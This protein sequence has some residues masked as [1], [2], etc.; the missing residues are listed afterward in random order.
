MRAAL[1]GL[2]D[3]LL[4][5]DL[6]TELIKA[7]FDQGFSSLPDIHIQQRAQGVLEA[8]VS[9]LQC[10]KE[11]SS[12]CCDNPCS[13]SVLQLDKGLHHTSAALVS[14]S[15]ACPH[16]NEADVRVHLKQCG[17]VSITQEHRTRQQLCAKDVVNLSL[18]CFH[19]C[20]SHRSQSGSC[21]RRYQPTDH[22][23]AWIHLAI[24]YTSVHGV[25]E[26]IL[27]SGT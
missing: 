5:D 10:I 23:I 21:R 14:I 1:L 9:C 13:L 25:Q 24:A 20:T 11:L 16:C 12:P 27:C 17:G 15:T 3:A 26:L 4:E 2:Q 18:R 22:M 6:P 19:L 8:F 7:C